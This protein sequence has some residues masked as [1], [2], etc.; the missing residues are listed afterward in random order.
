LPAGNVE[1]ARWQQSPERCRI[2][3]EAILLT[4]AW[5]CSREKTLDRAQDERGSTTRATSNTSMTDWR[6]VARTAAVP[7]A[8][9]PWGARTPCARLAGPDSDTGIPR[10]V[11]RSGNPLTAA[12]CGDAFSEFRIL[13]GVTF[14]LDSGLT[15]EVTK[16]LNANSLAQ[17]GQSV[18]VNTSQPDPRSSCTV[19]G[20]HATPDRVVMSAGINRRGLVNITVTSLSLHR[21]HRRSVIA[22]AP[23]GLLK[24]KRRSFRAGRL[25]LLGH[26]GPS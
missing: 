12:T 26:R 15:P 20:L 17:T 18:E 21:F 7:F 23:Q 6:P 25:A 5:K 10:R 3:Q 9:S 1:V 2:D 4:G 22:N 24:E 16:V 8:T 13:S 11:V 14:R 19:S